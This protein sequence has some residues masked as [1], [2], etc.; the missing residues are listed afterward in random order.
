[1]KKLI[2]ILLTVSLSLLAVKPGEAAP[3]SAAGKSQEQASET[4]LTHSKPI[5]SHR[6]LWHVFG[7]RNEYG[8][9]AHC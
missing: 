5:C 2:V 7:K 1:M 3:V 4:A 8:L 6:L 9:Q